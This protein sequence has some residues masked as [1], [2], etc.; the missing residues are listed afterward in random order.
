ME[1]VVLEKFFVAELTELGLYGVEL[2]AQGH[3]VFITL[4]DLEN[5]C[6]QL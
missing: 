5:L 1:V 3:V 2:I 6:L 4:L